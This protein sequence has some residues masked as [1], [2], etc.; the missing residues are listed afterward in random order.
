MK[1]KFEDDLALD[2]PLKLCRLTII[3][4][5]V[6]EENTKFYGQ[7]YLDGCLCELGKCC[8]T[9]KLISQKVLI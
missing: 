9:K 4:R 6:F 1:I 7:V 3:V 8:S 2:K 5:S